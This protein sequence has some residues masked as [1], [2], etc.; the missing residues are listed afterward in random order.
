MVAGIGAIGLALMYGRFARYVPSAGGTYAIVRA[1]LGRDAGFLSGWTLL[2]VGIIFVPGLLI[3]AAFLLQNFFV[4]VAPLH[5]FLSTAGGVG[6][7]SSAAL[8]IVDLVLRASR[9]R[10]ACSSPS[11]RSG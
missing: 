2:A 11:R 10:R 8:V 4:L 7:S 1:G 9:S 6:R 5:P 3:A